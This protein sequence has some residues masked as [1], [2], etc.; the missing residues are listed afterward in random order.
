MLDCAG[1]AAGEPALD[2][3]VEVLHGKIEVIENLMDKVDALII[4]GG[5]AYTFYKAMGL[6]IGTLPP[7]PRR[8]RGRR[9]SAWEIAV[10]SA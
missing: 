5:M 7:G 6:E 2:G 3:D 1:A 9:S 10:R 8:S 4:G